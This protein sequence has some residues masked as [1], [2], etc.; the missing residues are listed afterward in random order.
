MSARLGEQQDNL[1]LLLSQCKLS[2]QEVG[3]LTASFQSPTLTNPQVKTLRAQARA[4]PH[5]PDDGFKRLLGSFGTVVEEHETPRPVWLRPC[6]WNRASFSN[7]A[8]RFSGVAGNRFFRFLFATQSPMYACFC[9]MEEAEYYLPTGSAS[10]SEWVER[11]VDEWSHHFS[12]E[13]EALVHWYDLP[14]AQV[15][16]IHVLPDV[17]MLPGGQLVSDSDFVSLGVFLS[18]LPPVKQARAGAPKA[19]DTPKPDTGLLAQYPWMTKYIQEGAADSPS[20]PTSRAH[21]VEP[22]QDEPD[23]LDDDQVQAVFQDLEQRRQAWDLNAPGDHA[24]FRVTLLGGAWQ[25][26]HKGTTYVAFKG[27]VRQGSTS[28]HWCLQYNMPKSARFEISLYGEGGAYI[29]ANAWC[30]RLNFLCSLYA[31]CQGTGFK[32]HANCMADYKEP[33]EFVVF[34]EAAPKAQL[35]RVRWLRSLMPS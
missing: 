14:Q 28:E 9:E 5:P 4:T 3:D 7:V 11:A 10:L 23:A 33:P 25:Q 34:A 32:Y 27:A 8:L 18:W 2:S 13:F 12:M 6:C 26:R 31:E 17:H 24:D 22:P 21:P 20:G 15:E 16:D 19:E 1:P 30:H 29:M 35:N